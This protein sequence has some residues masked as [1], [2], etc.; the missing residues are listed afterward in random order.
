M[1]P[2]L[3]DLHQLQLDNARAL[4]AHTT[5]Y[6][7]PPLE[8]SAAA[9]L[10]SVIDGLCELSLRD[11]LTGLANRRQFQ[12][13]LERA[14]DMVARSGEPALLLMLDIDHFK[15]V[16]DNYGH[17][18]GDSVLQ[19]IARSLSASV[20]PMDTVA[21]LGGEEFAILLPSCQPSY[22][23]S[24][25][26]RLRA[27]IEEQSIAITPNLS[28]QITISVG[29]AFAHEWVRTTPSLWLERADVQLY[30][31]K[32]SGRNRVELDQQQ[33]VSVSAEE[34]NFLFGQLA[35]TGINSLVD[36]ASYTGAETISPPPSAGE[37][38]VL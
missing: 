21:R 28:L 11:P 12:S 34:K 35:F 22:G 24:V 25:A 13:V 8:E 29:G 20:R 7:A 33:D 6:Q 15:Q 16:N 30:R 26:E 32:Q 5:E 10:Q 14:I 18:A 4:L 1:Q 2:A 31:A 23:I 9:Y 38:R 19:A 37:Q 36:D 27:Q 3:V 17:A